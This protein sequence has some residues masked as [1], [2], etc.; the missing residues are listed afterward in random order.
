V[1]SFHQT[2]LIEISAREDDHICQERIRAALM[3]VMSGKKVFIQPG[4]LIMFF[5]I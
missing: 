1:I 4:I 2:F 3:V 5:H